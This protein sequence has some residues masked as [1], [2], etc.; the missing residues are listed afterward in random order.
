[1]LIGDDHAPTRGGVRAVLEADGFEICAEASDAAES[2]DL[3]RETKPDI[4]IL[5]VNM[6]GGGVQ[7]ARRIIEERPTTSVVM[8]TVSADDNDLFDALKAG[9]SGYLLKDIDPSR[10]GPVLRAVLDGEA[11]LPRSLTARLIQEFQGR[12]RRHRIPVLRN[13][14][15]TLTEKEWLVL[16]LMRDGASTAEM[17][18]RLGISAVTVRTH[19]SAILRKLRVSNRQEAVDLMQDGDD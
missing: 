16:E 17:A 9:A 13:R 8:L 5:D 6:P 19:V 14:G 18:E 1:V 7:A 3:A 2:V 4:C 10:L 12:E 11:A 15:V